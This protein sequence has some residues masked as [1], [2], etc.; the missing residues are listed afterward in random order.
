MLCHGAET[1]RSGKSSF[2]SLV[3]G[4]LDLLGLFTIFK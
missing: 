3:N 4:E 2:E 1:A